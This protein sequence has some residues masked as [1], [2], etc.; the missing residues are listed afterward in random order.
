MPITINTLGDSASVA[1]TFTEVS[2]DRNTAEWYNSTDLATLD[3]RVTIKQTLS[4]KGASGVRRTLVQFRIKK[5][6]GT[7]GTY[8]EGTFNCT[9]T[10]PEG[11]A[12]I[13]DKDLQDM[14]FYAR[15][16]FGTANVAALRRGEV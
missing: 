6:V 14:A 16:F 11:G 3:G 7:T 1:K 9:F 8:E 12:T 4:R 15:N 13:T 5:P 10:A 2:K